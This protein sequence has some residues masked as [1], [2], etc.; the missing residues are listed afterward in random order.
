MSN[1]LRKI[2]RAAHMGHYMRE[3]M[4]GMQ[5]IEYCMRHDDMVEK[6]LN[7]NVPGITTDRLCGHEV[8]V[9]LTTYGKRLLD[10]SPTIESIMQGS[11]KPNRIV[12]WLDNG[13]EGSPLPIALQRQCERGLEIAFC[14]DL[15]SYK[16]LIPALCKFPEAVVITIDDDA[17]Y[18]YDLVEKLVNAHKLYPHDIVANRVHRMVLGKD[19]CPIP[20]MEWNWCVNP[21]LEESSPLLFFTGVGGVLY[22]P[23]SFNSAVTDEAV[24]MEIC[25][26]ADDVWFNS[27][28]L[29]AGT[30][31]RKCYTHDVKGEDYILNEDVQDVGLLHINISKAGGNDRQLKAVYDKYGLW[32][33]LTES[34]EA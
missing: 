34:K 22:P 11:M 12:L 5:R 19:G 8:I 20:Y 17:I 25:K 23:G 21:P 1:L 31:V 9:S 30:K 14:K 28:A 4:H 27:M 16:K 2:K 10:V 18:N 26:S 15:R 13:L 33:K 29:M 24:F 3:V 32:N 7:C 6:A